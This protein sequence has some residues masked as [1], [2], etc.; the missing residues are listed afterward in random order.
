MANTD[1]S[2]TLSQIE[3]MTG[4][5]DYY[6][7]TGVALLTTERHSMPTDTG[8]VLLGNCFCPFTQRI[9][10]ALEYLGIDYQASSF[11]FFY[12][13]VTFSCLERGTAQYVEVEPDERLSDLLQVSPR[14]LVPGLRL[15]AYDPPRTLNENAI[16]LDYL[17]E[18]AANTT[19]R[20]LL[21]PLSSP[22]T[23]FDLHTLSMMPV[24]LTTSTTLSIDARALVRIQADHV[25]RTLVPAFY[26]FLQA[27][28]PIVQIMHGKEFRAA[29]EDL[30]DMMYRSERETAGGPAESQRALGLWKEGGD[31]GWTD[32]LAGPWLFRASRVLKEYR[33]FEMPRDA[34]FTAW[35]ERLFKHPAFARTCSSRKLYIEYYERMESLSSPVM[36]AA[37][38]DADTTPLKMSSEV[39]E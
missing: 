21:P 18:L 34:R 35:L 19:H 2:S 10:V 23:Q 37:V 16:I 33:A 4:Q 17:E 26:R 12:T 13:S 22:C 1:T 29:L 39:Q 20:S 7:A 28:D 11:S 32:A 24:V 5:K 15:D 36:R 3:P 8:I 6:H 27:Q 31:L 38:Y 14:R 9:W 30:I 25:S